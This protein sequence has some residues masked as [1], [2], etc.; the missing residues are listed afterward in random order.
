[1]NLLKIIACV[2]AVAA[3]TQ[4]EQTREDTQ[5][6]WGPPAVYTVNYPLAYFA[7]RI[8]G[9]SV[10]VVFPAPAD[11]DPA[12]WSPPT[13]TIADYQQA[14]LVLLNGAGY[15][16]WIQRATMSQSRLVDTSAALAD[17]LIPVDDTV[18]HSHGPGGDHSHQG[19]AFTTWLD[20]ELAIGQAHAVFDALVRLR[21]EDETVF[22]ERLT[23]LEKDLGELDSRLKVVA[24]RIGD[25]P[26]VFSHPVFQ[27]LARAYELNGRSVHWEPHETPGNDQWRELSDALAMHAAAWMIWEDEPLA[28]TENRL[29]AIG[30]RSLVFRPC[31]N[32][33]AG[34]SLVS[35]ML[36]NVMAL[37]RAFPA[38][39]L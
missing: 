24:E 10:E 29:E 27:Y 23:E 32:R 21:P 20:M 26:L 4:D 31:G 17:R 39:E 13:E 36:D 2:L 16:D 35:V 15:A 5:A 37:E 7:E 8:A 3:C 28:E 6:M 22:R 34:G 12:T 18:T 33:P 38:S 25:Q 1:M 9:D 14:D 11:V 19:T 30:I